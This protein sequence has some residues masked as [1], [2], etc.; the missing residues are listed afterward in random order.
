MRAICDGGIPDVASTAPETRR[1][2]NASMV[3]DIIVARRSQGTFA[4][5]SPFHRRGSFGRDLQLA[6]GHAMTLLLIIIVLFLLFGGGGYYG[7]RGGYY[8]GGGFSLFGLLLII[9]V[10]VAIFGHGRYY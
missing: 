6:K 9:L 4:V 1:L 7:Y 8:G 2:K 10:V 5:G 3:K